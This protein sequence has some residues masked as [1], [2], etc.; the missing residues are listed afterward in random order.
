M[1][2]RNRNTVRCTALGLTNYIIRHKLCKSTLLELVQVLCTQGDTV[3]YVSHIY[4]L[5]Y[6][7]RTYPLCF[8]GTPRLPTLDQSALFKSMLRFTAIL[9]KQLLRYTVMLSRPQISLH[10]S[11]SKFG[12]LLK[13]HQE[14]VKLLNRA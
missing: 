5:I 10:C 14:N 7:C 3:K 13:N 11:N 9:Q 1:Y 6:E 2:G 12:N 4:P 8:T